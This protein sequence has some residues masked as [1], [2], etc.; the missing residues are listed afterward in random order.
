MKKSIIILLALLTLTAAGCGRSAEKGEAAR[1]NQ[2]SKLTIND[3]LAASQAK[4][5]SSAEAVKQDGYPSLDYSADVDLTKMGSNMVYSTVYAMMNEGD[6]Y[7]GKSVKASGTFEVSTDAKTGKTYYFCVVS[8]ATACCAQGLEFLPEEG[9]RYPDDFPE[10][11]APITIGG[12]FSRY[13][14]NGKFY[15]ALENTQIGF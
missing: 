14:E 6:S 15:R 9:L 7:L 11:G 1:G 13:E 3:I 5:Q 4:E 2:S 8:D 12:T 10:S